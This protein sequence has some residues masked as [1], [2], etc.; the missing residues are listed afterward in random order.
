MSLEHFK[1]KTFEGEV[2]FLKKYFA[3]NTFYGKFSRTSLGTTSFAK[4]KIKCCVTVSSSYS[5]KPFIFTNSLK[6]ISFI[7][8]LTAIAQPI[9]VFP[10]D[11][12]P[13]INITY[14]RTAAFD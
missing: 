6:S 1:A 5:S 10:D 9:E 14:G 3:W 13:S 7:L 8:V 4:L 11:F 2:P 12:G